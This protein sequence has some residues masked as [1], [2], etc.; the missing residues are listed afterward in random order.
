MKIMPP[1]IERHVNPNTESSHLPFPIFF[2]N[3]IFNTFTNMLKSNFSIVSKNLQIL[4]LAYIPSNLRFI[5]DRFIYLMNNITNSLDKIEK[6]I[7]EAEALI[8][9]GKSLEAKSILIQA[10]KEINII[11]ITYKELRLASEEFAKAFYLPINEMRLRLDSLSQFINEINQRILLLLNKIEYQIMLNE[12]FLTIDV[13][14][15]TVWIG[16]VITIEGKL[17]TQNEP[18]FGKKVSI[19][20]NELKINE[21]FTNLNGSFNIEVKLPYIYESSI[22]VQAK[23][24]PIDMDAEIYKP[25]ISNV[26]KV[27]LLYIEPEI[28]IESDKI[29]L[30]GKT[31]TIKGKV[32]AN[33]PLP[34]SNVKIFWLNNVINTELLN[35]GSFEAMLYTP[36]D[37]SSGKYDIIV[38]TPA[39]GIFAPTSTSLSIL[40]E[41]M[42]INI[43]INAPRFALTG[44]N[45][46]IEGSAKS[47]DEYLNVS[48]KVYFIGQEYSFTSYGN[49]TFWLN[50]PI[51]LLSSFQTFKIRITPIDP[52]YNEAIWE[53]NILIINPIAI[54]ALI[55]FSYFFTIKAFGNKSNTS[56][57]EIF[58]EVTSNF[59]KNEIYF[60]NK[61]LKWLI[62]G[63]WE[64]VEIISNKT[65]VKMESHMTMREFLKATA[66]KL[67]E[68]YECFEALTS[69]TERA[70]YSPNVPTWMISIA[71]KALE[72]IKNAQIKS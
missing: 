4:E 5:F 9:I 45:T 17:T 12:T 23:Y 28:I 8:N 24:I 16:D 29:A 36:T 11:N 6:L 1:I 14:P 38:N 69:A 50:I 10:S 35:D 66:S 46:F 26:I 64:A 44:L 34:Y 15:K 3:F 68:L 22:D 40:I 7:D 51:M 67:S 53:G 70:L 19:F 54:L 27:N 56:I 18:L 71:K 65:G 58:E 31:F 63:Y 39:S 25:S 32:Q 49:F 37:I 59:N 21:V 33:S 30:P 72:S 62:D 42:P 52:W 2:A 57:E 48:I 20:I 47:K 43:T 13:K 60:T 55:G 41:R 61:E